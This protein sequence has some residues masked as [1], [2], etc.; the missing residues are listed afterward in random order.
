MDLN[1]LDF[2][3]WRV[4]KAKGQA[5]THNNLTAKCLSIAEEWDW[6]AAVSIRKNCRSFRCRQQAAAKKN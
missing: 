4:L 2:T 5:M 3:I 6:L 1:L